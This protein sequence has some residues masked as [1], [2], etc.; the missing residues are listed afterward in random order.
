M[1]RLRRIIQWWALTIAATAVLLHSATFAADDSL[2]AAKALLV[3]NQISTTPDS[4]AAYLAKQCP[5]AAQL[6][7]IAAS[8]AALGHDDYQ[9][10]RQASAALLS[11][12]TPA[13]LPLHQA[14]DSPDLEIAHAARRLWQQIDSP[15]RSARQRELLRA[16][17]EVL[18][19]D[20][21]PPAVPILLQLLSLYDDED[22][23]SSASSA[24]WHSTRA[25][26][27]DLLMEVVREDD[28]ADTAHSTAG[29]TPRTRLNRRAAAVVALELALGTAAID[30][31]QPL[32]SSDSESLRLAAARALVDRLPQEAIPALVSLL[33]SSDRRIQ[34]QAAWLLNEIAPGE[35]TPQ[36]ELLSFEKQVVR[37][38]EL[39]QQ[40]TSGDQAKPLGSRRL[41]LSLYPLMFTETFAESTDSIDG[42]Y[43]KFRFE[44]TVPAK[45]TVSEGRLRLACGQNEGDQRLV[46]AAHDVFGSKTFP[47]GFSVT[48]VM[49][50]GEEGT[51]GYHVGLSIGRLKFLFHPAYPGGGFRV[52]DVQTHD[53]LVTN[54]D[55][56]FTPTG[57]TLHTMHVTVSPTAVKDRLAF[58]VI[59]TS[60]TDRNG[61]YS[62]HYECDRQQCGVLDRIGLERSGRT[63]SAAEFDSLTIDLAG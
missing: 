35:L 40:V 1:P 59:I 31:V 19:H 29:E 37:W 17:L 25:E 52:E 47:D 8:I 44:T 45:A 2:A 48:S 11:I 6:K 50:G 3:E 16:A 53:Y 51:G 57:G 55:M 26:H 32:L 63:G 54:Q 24:L 13:A 9:T 58:D 30:S 61:K 60:G 10:R 46:I 34:L 4:L 39:A 28:R 42:R 49:G 14:F 20:P 22:L 21:H 5:S 18:A 12:G 27:G 15:D 43:R 62:Y 41:Q 36:G 33:E 23:S 7:Q 56:S 38:R